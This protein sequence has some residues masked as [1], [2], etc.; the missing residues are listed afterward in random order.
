MA[1]AIVNATQTFADVV[2]SGTVDD[3]IT[4]VTFHSAETGGDYWFTIDVTDVEDLI[5]GQ[6][7][8]FPANMVT[9]TWT[10]ASSASAK[11]AVHILR[12]AL[13]DQGAWAQLH[14]GAPGSAGSNNILAGFTDRLEFAFSEW[15]FSE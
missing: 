7:I 3:D 6:S 1:T 10:P 11:W 8:R 2:P 13:R 9:L 5:L 12:E 15:G 14:D 4:H